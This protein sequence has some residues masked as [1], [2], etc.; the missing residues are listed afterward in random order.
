[1]RKP[2]EREAEILR[3]NALYLVLDRAAAETNHSGVREHLL[4][5]RERV[6]AASM[7]LAH[8]GFSEVA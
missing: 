8:E 1:M 7:L 5:A 2:S 3:L 6:S 4:S